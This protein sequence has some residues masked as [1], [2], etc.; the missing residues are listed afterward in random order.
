MLQASPAT[1]IV[2]LTA[3]LERDPVQGCLRAGARGY[4]LKEA[5]NP[6]LLAHIEFKLKDEPKKYP[7]R[8]MTALEFTLVEKGNASEGKMNYTANMAL[9]G[10]HGTYKDSGVSYLMKGV[11]L[12]FSNAAEVATEADR[13]EI[14]G[15]VCFR[16]A[17]KAKGIFNGLTDAQTHTYDFSG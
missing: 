14:K 1:A 3:F 8:Y 11:L 4:L 17:C 7:G 5:Q 15:Q 9:L 2:A 6:R 13:Q 10:G 16:S 12:E